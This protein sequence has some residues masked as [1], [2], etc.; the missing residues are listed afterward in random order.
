MAQFRGLKKDKSIP[1]WLENIQENSWEAELLLSAV[2]LFG[3]IQTPM[4]LETWSNYVFAWGSTL[5]STFFEAIIQ[6]LQ[7]LRIGFIVHIIVR[8]MWIAQVGFSYVYPSGIKLNTL[9]FKGRFHSEL[10]KTDSTIKTILDL[11]RLAS[12][13]F[14]VSF[15]LFGLMLG[16]VVYVTPFVLMTWLVTIPEIN[17]YSVVAF[18][19]FLLLY[20]PLS[21]LVFIDFITNG[22]LRR[23]K[24]RAKFFYHISLFFRFMT[25]SFLYRKT[26]LTIISNAQGYKRYVITFSLLLFVVFL[27]E[28]SSLEN[29]YK[30]ENYREG[31]KNAYLQHSNYESQRADKD[32]VVATVPNDIIEERIIP[33]FVKDLRIFKDYKFN[34]RKDSGKAFT[35]RSNFNSDL[36]NI[37]PEKLNLVLS[38]FIDSTRFDSLKWMPTVH[39]SSYTRGYITYLNLQAFPNELH[40]LTVS[41]K[42]PS[43]TLATAEDS[44]IAFIPF[45]LNK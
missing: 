20:L 14:A 32:L 25:L 39:P 35:V 6:G 7:I 28:V 26:L 42:I 29:N 16:L 17:E 13:I 4:Y 3:L 11:E 36:F 19:V 45:Y 2:L 27:D 30:L 18:G 8:S 40:N 23:G 34:M 41:V 33:L 5:L 31:I 24:R 38:V 43:D 12:T 22:F 10:D 15:M 9:K 37:S 21:L 44:T 1:R